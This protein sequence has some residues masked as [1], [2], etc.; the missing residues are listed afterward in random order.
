MGTAL[1]QTETEFYLARFLLGLAEAGF[2]PGVIV[3]FTHWFPREVRARAMSGM[4]IAVPV[5]LSLGRV[6][7]GAVAETQLAGRGGVAMGVHSGRRPAVLLGIGLP[8][9]LT[10]RPRD[11]KWLTAEE[12]DWLETTLAAERREAATGSARFGPASA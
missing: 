7:F 4:L 5:S 6:S 9:L 1:V 10:D 3:Y 2:F 8:F 12:R 11:A